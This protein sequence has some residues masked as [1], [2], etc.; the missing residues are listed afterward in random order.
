MSHIYGVPFQSNQ[1]L[2]LK[3]KRRLIASFFC[4]NNLSIELLYLFLCFFILIIIWSFYQEDPKVI[5]TLLYLF[6]HL[7]FT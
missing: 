6:H 5:D 4:N 7:H 2:I 3:T 1:D